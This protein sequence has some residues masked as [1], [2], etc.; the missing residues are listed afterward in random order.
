MWEKTGS[1]ASQ[2][3]KCVDDSGAAPQKRHVGSPANLCWPLRSFY[4][5]CV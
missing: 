1:V 3:A 4:V 5:G 2:H